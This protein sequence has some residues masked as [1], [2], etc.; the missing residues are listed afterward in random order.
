M[1]RFRAVAECMRKVTLERRLADLRPKTVA[2]AHGSTR[3][4]S[5]P[6]SRMTSKGKGTPDLGEQL[7]LM[8]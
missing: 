8:N 5:T 3:A 7:L 2:A 4:A 1:Y 6:P